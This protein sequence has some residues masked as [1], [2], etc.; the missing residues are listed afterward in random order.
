MLPTT[1]SALIAAVAAG[2]VAIVSTLTNAWNT[3]RTLRT[4]REITGDG[5]VWTE[6]AKAYESVLRYTKLRQMRR[7]HETVGHYFSEEARTAAVEEIK[8]GGSGLNFFALEASVEAWASDNAR[9]LF[10]ASRNTELY[11]SEIDRQWAAA[12]EVA[13]SNP[14]GPEAAFL[15]T[16]KPRLDEAQAKANEARD[17]LVDAIRRELRDGH[18]GR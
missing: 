4:N 8:R 6:R 14:Q 16:F 1:E 11:A 17:A 9:G 15:A 3:A 18:L 2:G 13:V 5:R 10:Y 12:K 7:D